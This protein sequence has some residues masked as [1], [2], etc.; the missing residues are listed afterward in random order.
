MTAYI[1]KQRI[2]R[3]TMQNT[4]DF[5]RLCSSLLREL[6]RNEFIVN[7]CRIARLSACDAHA[8]FVVPCVWR[9]ALPM[10]THLLDLRSALLT[11][12]LQ[13]SNQMVLIRDVYTSQR[14]RRYLPAPFFDNKKSTSI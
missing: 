14:L 11:H 13:R 6:Q 9:L 7:Q 1:Y 12:R 8:H 10:L 4:P 3:E 5:E 2:C